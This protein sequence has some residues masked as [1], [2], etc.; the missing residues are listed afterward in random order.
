M[1]IELTER[2]FDYI[3]NEML[4]LAEGRTGKPD[5]YVDSLVTPAARVLALLNRVSPE[6]RKTL[7]ALAYEQLTAARA[8]GE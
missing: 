2:E 3:L 1:T 7:A 8:D 4:F 6:D 5:S